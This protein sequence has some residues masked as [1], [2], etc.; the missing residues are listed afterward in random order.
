MSVKAASCLQDKHNPC[1]LELKEHKIGLST[2]TIYCG[3]PTCAD[4]LL[5]LSECEN[6]QQIMANVVKRHSRQ[7]RITVH[8]DKSNAVLLNKPKS[9]SKKTFSLELS[10]RAIPLSSS[11]THLDLL[12]SKTNEN[13]INI[14]ECLKLARH[15]LYALI[16]TQLH[17]SNGL[18]LRVSYKIYQLYVIPRLLFGLEA[19]GLTY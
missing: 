17:G 16:N 1:L 3:C 19:L 14:E 7:D 13:V 4:D 5:L 9:Y 11:T 10:E 2:G 8:P 15:T 12:R 18:N 6:E